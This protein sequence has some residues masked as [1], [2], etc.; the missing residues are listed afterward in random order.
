MHLLVLYLHRTSD[1]MLYAVYR[2]NKFTYIYSYR[3]H[4]F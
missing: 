2:F 4:D 1:E 3:L